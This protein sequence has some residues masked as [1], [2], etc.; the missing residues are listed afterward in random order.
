MY[1]QVAKFL[2][3]RCAELGWDPPGAGLVR[4]MGEQGQ[5]VSRQRVSMWINGER[6]PESDLWPTLAAALRL[7]KAQ[8]AEMLRVMGVAYEAPSRK[9]RAA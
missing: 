5:E 7:D 6:R 4:A 2:T 8:W 1:P 3:A 9:D